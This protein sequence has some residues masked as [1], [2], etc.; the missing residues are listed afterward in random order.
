MKVPLQSA[1]RVLA[2]IARNNGGRLPTAYHDDILE[3]LPEGIDMLSRTGTLA[4]TSTP[5]LNEAG[6]LVTVNHVVKIPCD[7]VAIL[8]IEDQ[9]GQRIPEG[10]DITDIT[11]PTTA[12]ASPA[13]VARASVFE[14]NPLVHQTEDGVPTTAPGTSIPIYGEDLEQV[15]SVSSNGAYYKVSGN[16]IQTSFESGFI[17]VHYLQRPLDHDGYPMIPDN[18]NFRTALYW[19]V[20]RMLIGAGYEHPVF[21]YDACDINFEKFAAR[22]IGEITYPSLDEYARIEASFIRLVPPRHF[23]NDFF[24]NSEQTQSIVK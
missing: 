10:G 8:A 21:K 13:N 17:K 4:T 9:F 3:W 15:T 11:R 22:A 2:D 14:V 16:C 19:Y 12:I 20:M 7:L 24:I 1:K 6:S 23:T 5:S 18:Q